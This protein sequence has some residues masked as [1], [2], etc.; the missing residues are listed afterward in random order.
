MLTR[1]KRNVVPNDVTDANSV[2]DSKTT[3]KKVLLPTTSSDGY[4][5][6]EQNIAQEF[7]VPID[8]KTTTHSV[9]PTTHAL[10]K[11]EKIRHDHYVK[12]SVN[13]ND[14]GPVTP[15]TNLKNKNYEKLIGRE[16]MGGRRMGIQEE[17]YGTE[18]DLSLSGLTIYSLA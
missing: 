16:G 13:D 18:D 6:N 11:D 9:K 8:L 5:K 4:L 2:S 15:A 1:S 7:T 3:T 12:F 17:D 14:D 10:T